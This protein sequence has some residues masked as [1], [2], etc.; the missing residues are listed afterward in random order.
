MAKK[1]TAKKKAAKKEKELTDEDV[2]AFFKVCEENRSLKAFI[3]GQRKIN[4]RLYRSIELIG[5]AL[6][7][8]PG[9]TH[10]GCVA[11]ACA[12]NDKVPGVPPGCNPGGLPGGNG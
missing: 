9:K 10:D 11:T 8:G 7:A 3:R 1:K 12:I 6:Q 2:F 4:G 5:K